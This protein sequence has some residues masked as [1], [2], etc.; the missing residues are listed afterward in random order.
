[1]L[2][3]AATPTWSTL[4]HTTMRHVLIALV[5][6][7]L[8]LLPCAAEA[9]TTLLFEPSSAD[10]G[11]FPTNVLTKADPNQKTGL[12]VNLAEAPAC[13]GSDFVSCLLVRQLL[14]Q[15]D[16]FSVDP[17][18]RLCFSGAIDI[19]TV[20]RG[21]S[22]VRDDGSG[23]AL[24]V[25]Q[26]FYDPFFYDAGHGRSIWCVL[27]KP[28]HVLD[29]STRYLLIVTNRIHEALGRPIARDDAFKNCLKDKGT[30]YCG[31]L[32][33]AVKKTELEDAGIVGASLFTTMSATDWMEKARQ[34]LRASPFLPTTVP[35]GLKTVFDLSDLQSFDWLPQT[36]I[37]LPPTSAIPVPLQ[38]LDGVQKVAFGLFLS[39]NFIQTSGALAGSIAVTPTAGPIQNPVPVSDPA[40]APFP[41]G[42][43]PISYHVYL[44]AAGE[45]NAK[46]PVVIYGHGYGD[47]Q[48]GGPT[49]IASTLA[50]AGF[51]TLAIEEFGFGF[52]PGSLAS[53]TDSTGH[54]FVATPG[55]SIPLQ[56]DGSIHPGDGCVLP[57]P[58]GIRDCLRQSAVDVMAVVQNIEANGLGVNL[59]PSRIYYVGQSLGSFIGSLV[60]AVE[61]L[62]NAAVLNVGG[63][64][65]VDTA[66]LAFGDVLADFYL[67]SYNPALAAVV[68]DA[69]ALDPA[70]DYSFPY[71]DQLTES[72]GPG[73]GD[74]QR[75]FEVADWLNIPGSP[76]A[77]APHFQ[78]RPLQGVPAKRTLF[79]FGF[80]DLEVTNPTQSGLVRATMPP[81]YNPDAPLP[82][83][84]WR[85]DLA[86]ADNPHLAHVF[87]EGLPI[88][89]LPHRILANPSLLDPA[90]ADELA[91]TLDMQRQV[92]DFFSSRPIVVP[93]PFFEVPTLSTLPETRNF[94]WPFEF[95]PAP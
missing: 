94:T 23:R 78:T 62:V 40:L 31:V 24:G 19:T 11:P 68:G 12:R 57:G 7:G 60:H 73:V 71:R 55:R 79:Q 34:F 32:A 16:G 49:A 44:P 88:S 41:P 4:C 1:M 90:N 51:A 95:A 65:T 21:V 22:I 38:V 85:F 37:T 86:V 25:N 93:P 43:V 89:A 2:R 75:V 52:G 87:M 10:V 80:G 42:Y 8:F 67:F 59:D 70:F 66:R 17:Q 81:T 48:F 39:P 77:F 61:P 56:P 83:S 36:N 15:L 63:D 64:S 91:I 76:L 58:I 28:E 53:L 3:F 30:G 54:Y 69:P 82:V 13:L 26:V 29:Q 5:C 35:A 74:I 18:I 33:R 84:Y 46:I 92:A 72:P 14:N 45:P 47:S 27:A 9:K 20:Q 6:C 50:K